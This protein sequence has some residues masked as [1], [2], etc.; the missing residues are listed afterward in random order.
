M[1]LGSV[2]SIL[3]EDLC[4]RSVSAKFVRSFR[5]HNPKFPGQEQ[6]TT[7]PTGYL[8]S[9]FSSVWRR[10][11]PHSENHAEREAFLIATGNYEKSDGGQNSR[12]VPGVLIAVAEP[13]GEV[14]ELPREVF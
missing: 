7:Y 6:H 9:R 2:H 8:V 12:E 13:L 10:A 11:L 4:I 1:K 5:P 14:C 3:M